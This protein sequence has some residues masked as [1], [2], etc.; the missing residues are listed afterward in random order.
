[1]AYWEALCPPLGCPVRRTKASDCMYNGQQPIFILKEGTTR[2]S[3]KG[4]QSNN[5]A[6]AKAVADAVRSTL[7]PKGM[8]KMLVDSMGDVVITNDGATILKEMEIEHP[9]AKMIIEIAKTQEQHCFDGT[10]SAVVIAGEL[11]KRSEEL[12]DQNVHPTVICEG[13]R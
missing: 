1:M 7:G 8:D 5:I 2:T 12:V 4:A 13:F 10:T 3:G 9:A 6:A 11:L